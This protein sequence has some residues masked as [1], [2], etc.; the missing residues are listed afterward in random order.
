MDQC[1]LI[2]QALG[3]GMNRSVDDAFLLPCKFPIRD[4]RVHVGAHVVQRKSAISLQFG[5][6]SSIYRVINGIDR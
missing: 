6:G 4:L 5:S 1:R 2:H 3:G